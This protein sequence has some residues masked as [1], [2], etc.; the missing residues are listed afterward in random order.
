MRP[1]FTG[2]THLDAT[3]WILRP[4]LATMVI[5]IVLARL[6]AATSIARHFDNDHGWLGIRA[7]LRRCSLLGHR[8]RIHP[9]R[10]RVLPGCL[11][12]TTGKLFKRRQ[13]EKMIYDDS[14][15]SSFS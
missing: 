6:A 7:R 4:P 2:C 3:A 13:H 8:R 1:E 14:Y 11:R 9:R 15:Y 5:L 12:A 10:Y